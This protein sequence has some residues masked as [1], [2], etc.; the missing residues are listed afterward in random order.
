MHIVPDRDTTNILVTVLAVMPFK[1]DRAILSRILASATWRLHFASIVPEAVRQLSKCDQFPL[2]LC[3][4]DKRVGSW[5]E[6]LEHLHSVSAP[7]LL[8]VV[9][10]CADEQLWAQTLNLGGYDVLAKPFDECE[11]NRTLDLACM[12]YRRQ[13]DEPNIL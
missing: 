9:S 4:A 5:M 12:R 8:I 3:E 7:S 1:E 10:R 11:V 6:L 2:I 13:F